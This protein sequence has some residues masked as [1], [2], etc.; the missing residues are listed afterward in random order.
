MIARNTARDNYT[1]LDDSD[2]NAR[3]SNFTIS[4][5]LAHGFRLLQ[6]WPGSLVFFIRAFVRMGCEG[7]P[8]NRPHSC[9]APHQQGSGK[10]IRTPQGRSEGE[11]DSEGPGS[12]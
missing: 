12:E 10:G 4:Y 2:C 7:P 11:I 3:P 6:L 8:D 1:A 5:E 9:Q